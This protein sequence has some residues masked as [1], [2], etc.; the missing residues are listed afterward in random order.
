MANKT[1]IFFSNSSDGPVYL[2]TQKP[3]LDDQY[4][5]AAIG[6]VATCC[7]NPAKEENPLDQ[8]LAAWMVKANLEIVPWHAQMLRASAKTFLD[9]R[10][11]TILEVKWANL[12]NQ[13]LARKPITPEFAELLTQMAERQSHRNLI[14]HV[15]TLKGAVTGVPRVLRLLWRAIK[16]RLD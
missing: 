15:S 11:G 6:L 13:L 5:Y 4:L 1:N 2:P 10:F 7:L 12:A 9:Y 8:T 14:D 3:A 16:N